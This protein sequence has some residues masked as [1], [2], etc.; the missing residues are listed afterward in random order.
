MRLAHFLN[1]SQIGVDFALKVL[2]W[3]PPSSD[4]A[5]NTASTGSAVVRLQLWYNAWMAMVYE[6]I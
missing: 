3:T 5:E 6:S 1:T 4:G 2:Q